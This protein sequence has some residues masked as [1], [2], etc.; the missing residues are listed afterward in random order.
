MVILYVINC[1]ISHSKVMMMIMVTGLPKVIWN[2]SSRVVITMQLFLFVF[3]TEEVVYINNC[4][5]LTY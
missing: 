3:K 5:Y 4:Y 1:I 2:S